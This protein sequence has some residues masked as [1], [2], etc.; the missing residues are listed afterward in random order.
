MSRCVWHCLEALSL[1]LSLLHDFFSLVS[2]GARIR[3]DGEPMGLEATREV[4][5]PQRQQARGRQ[6]FG[7]TAANRVAEPRPSLLF[8]PVSTAGRP[9]RSSTDISAEQ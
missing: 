2:P 5:R 4:T 1:G 3:I 7:A 8:A 9:V 6:N